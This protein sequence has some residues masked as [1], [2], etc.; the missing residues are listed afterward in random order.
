MAADAVSVSSE[1][2]FFRPMTKADLDEVMAI[3]RTA[4][5]FPWSSGFFLQ[6]LQV[7]CARSI[8]AELDGRW[9][10]CC[11]GCCPAPSTFIILRFIS[12]FAG[13]ASPAHF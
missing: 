2:L 3:E 7:A 10:T 4:Y 12:S 6:E 11:S 5:R 1:T 13:A 9:A 8:L